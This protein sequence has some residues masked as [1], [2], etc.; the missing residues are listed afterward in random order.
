MGF[1][2]FIE[3]LQKKPE[4]AR[5]RIVFLSALAITSLIFIFWLIAFNLRPFQNQ[6]KIKS[7]FDSIK[8]DFSK[9]YEFFK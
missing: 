2:Y 5:K 8:E 6:E 4:A 9:I 7:P 3:K 1:F